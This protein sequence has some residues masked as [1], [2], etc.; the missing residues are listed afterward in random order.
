MSLKAAAGDGHTPISRH[1]R[2]RRE[3]LTI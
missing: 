2:A 3:S 1:L